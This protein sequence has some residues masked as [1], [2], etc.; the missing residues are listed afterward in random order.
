MPDNS[1]R[2]NLIAMGLPQSTIIHTLRNPVDTCLSCYFQAFGPGVRYA[3][4]L[5]A[6]GVYY[7]GYRRLMD[8]WREVLPIEVQEVEYERLTED[9]EGESRRLI[10]ACGLAWDDACLRYYESGRVTMTASN[11]QVRQPMYRSS[12][13]RWR[14]YEKHLGPLLDALGK[15][16]P[17]A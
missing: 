2:L 1:I 8:H 7:S 11:E 15:H 16:A 6:L 17:D 3:T 4:R 12:V 10:D 9:Q 5:E 13:D 14:R